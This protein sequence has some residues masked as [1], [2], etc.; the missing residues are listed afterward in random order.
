LLAT[1]KANR[2]GSNRLGHDETLR[3]RILAEFLFE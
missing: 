2:V 3:R 1:V